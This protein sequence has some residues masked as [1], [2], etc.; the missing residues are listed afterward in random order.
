MENEC[1]AGLD[2]RETGFSGSIKDEGYSM[3]RIRRLLGS[4]SF[5]TNEAKIGCI[6]QYKLIKGNRKYG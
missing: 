6:S 4:H 3:M 5:K 2:D 1:L